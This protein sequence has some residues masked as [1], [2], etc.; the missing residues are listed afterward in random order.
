MQTDR[1]DADTDMVRSKG[2]AT[3]MAKMIKATGA[4]RVKV[5]NPALMSATGDRR[6]RNPVSQMMDI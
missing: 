4:P 5:V 6:P 2:S 3:R 1:A